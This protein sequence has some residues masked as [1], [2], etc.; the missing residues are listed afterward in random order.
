MGEIVT[1][2][3]Y[4]IC[5]TIIGLSIVIN[6]EFTGEINRFQLT[7]SNLEIFFILFITVVGF[8]IVYFFYKNTKKRKKYLTK[9][10]WIV[11]IDKFNRF[12]FIAIVSQ[13]VFV[14]MTSVGVVGS[15]ATS[16]IS[17]I[18][19]LLGLNVLFNF[20][21]FI[22]RRK[23]SR[24]YILN[25]V[26]F[27]ILRF[28]QGW[29]GFIF[30]IAIFEIYFYFKRKKRVRIEDVLK[31]FSLPTAGILAGG[32]I[33]QY[34][35][36]LK[37]ERRFGSIYELSYYEGL[38]NLVNRLT[39]INMS[40][41]AYQNLDI[42]KQLYLESGLLF[43]E[44]QGLFRPILPRFIMPYKE[45]RTLNNFIVQAFWPNIVFYTSS[46]FG[47][48]NYSLTLLYISFFD[49]LVWAIFTIALFSF[50]RRLIN[51]FERYKGQLDF[52]Y[53][54]LVLHVFTNG[55]PEFVFGYGYFQLIY[56]VPLL[57]M[58]KIIKLDRR[59]R[60]NERM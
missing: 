52:L 7:V 57:F 22:C 42:I 19:S 29:T 26:L 30:Y 35:Y 25:I 50:S 18:F 33:Y 56:V 23:K 37:F 1:L 12:F 13:I 40:I 60:S 59:K 32:K 5:T 34:A 10:K 48:I 24:I 47:L 3:I 17:F 55:S 27:S 31:V 9:S 11:D 28:V 39:H 4:I 38:I 43:A 44:A 6:R 16:G 14:S 54:L 58:L 41:G 20:Y 15:G 8:W 49:F 53:F 46:G 45:F 2:F 51:S 36:A 21:Y